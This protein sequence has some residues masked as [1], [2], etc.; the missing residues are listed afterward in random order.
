MN[1]DLLEAL[2]DALRWELRAMVMYGH[3][4]AHVTGLHRSHLKPYFEAEAAESM[5]H[6]STVRDALV[7]LGAKC[8][9]RLSD[10][11]IPHHKGPEEMLIAALATEQRAGECYLRVLQLLEGDDGEPTDRE[12]YDA[13]EAIYFDEERAVNELMQLLA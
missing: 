10:A 8:P 9:T 7:K 1:T 2:K 12:M 11:E 5:T 4:A 13:V 3:F 6:A